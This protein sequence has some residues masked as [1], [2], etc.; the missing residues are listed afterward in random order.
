MKDRTEIKSMSKR[1]LNSNWKLPVLLSGIVT[2]IT[3]FVTRQEIINEYFALSWVFNIITAIIGIYLTMLYINIAKNKGEGIV[4][5]EW[6]KVPFNK[7][8][9]CILCAIVLFLIV[10]GIG[11]LG[12]LAIFISGT[13]LI[14]SQVIGNILIVALVILDIVISIYL[15]FAT[16]LILDKDCKIIESLKLSFKL[17]KNSFWK[18]VLFGLSFI[19]WIIPIIITLGVAT[20][21]VMPY[22]GISYANYYLELY[23]EKIGN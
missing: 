2:L 21:W 11:M 12:M 18:T 23:N 20:I 7:L 3:A 17:V 16:Y 13:S 8:L 14:I 9:K 15:S 10:F 22:I 4:T 6:L 5:W 19:L 1:Q